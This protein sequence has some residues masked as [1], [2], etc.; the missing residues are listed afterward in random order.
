MIMKVYSTFPKLQYWS[1]TINLL[2][3]CKDA[4]DVF[5]IPLHQPTVLKGYP[6]YCSRQIRDIFS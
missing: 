3:I 6:F 2:P 1:F 5:Y 4:V